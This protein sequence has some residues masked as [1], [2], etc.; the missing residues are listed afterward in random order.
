MFWKLINERLLR[1][2][3][4]TKYNLFKWKTNWKGKNW[5]CFGICYQN[6]FIKFSKHFTFSCR[7]KLLRSIHFS[8]SFSQNSNWIFRLILTLA[9]RLHWKWRC[10]VNYAIMTW[11]VMKIW[12]VL[13]VS[14]KHCEFDYQY[15]FITKVN[16]NGMEFTKYVIIYSF[17]FTYF[18]NH[19][20]GQQSTYVRC[21]KVEQLTN[22]NKW[23]DSK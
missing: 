3:A 15:C 23:I 10:L 5:L 14:F 13:C 4:Q 19:P 2:T 22:E 9:Y 12:I 6:T 7:P 21:T 20:L 8:C 18:F 1:L 11:S 16:Y 17:F